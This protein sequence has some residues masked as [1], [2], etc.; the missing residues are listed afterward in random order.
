MAVAVPSEEDQ[1][2][3]RNGSDDLELDEDMDELLY[4]NDGT[5]IIPSQSNGST[6]HDWLQGRQH[7]SSISSN[8]SSFAPLSASS[9]ATSLPSPSPSNASLSCAT[10]DTPHTP[11]PP[12]EHRPS[13]LLT[14]SFSPHEIL[15]PIA[16]KFV[17]P[18]IPEGISL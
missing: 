3:S 17:E 18:R 10:I 2:R 8:A 1:P 5:Q 11:P 9:T 6:S 16:P 14:S 7:S 13:H 4:D 12:Q 15:S